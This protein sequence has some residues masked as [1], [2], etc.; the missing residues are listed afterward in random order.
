MAHHHEEH[1]TE[2][3]PVAFTVPLIFGATIMFIILLFVSLG[4]PCHGCCED[5]KADKCCKPGT[6]VKSDTHGH[7]AHGENHGEESHQH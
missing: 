5:E 2:K 3:K 4:D 6:E 7:E 1:E